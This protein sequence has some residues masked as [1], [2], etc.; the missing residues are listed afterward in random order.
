MVRLRML[1]I[2]KPK[3][4]SQ[5]AVV[6]GSKQSNNIRHETSRHFRTKMTEYLKDQT[7]E[8]TVKLQLFSLCVTVFLVNVVSPPTQSQNILWRNRPMRELL[9]FRNIKK[10]NCATVVSGVFSYPSFPPHRTLLGYAVPLDCTTVRKDHVTSMTSCVTIHN[11]VFS[12]C[13]TPV[14]ITE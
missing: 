4:T 14:F 7:N 3:N 13:Q 11:A 1:K 10:R 2:I 12:A 5:I 8:K 9:K 6:T